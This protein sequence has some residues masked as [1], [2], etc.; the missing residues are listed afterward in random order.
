[1]VA[2]GGAVELSVHFNV[3]GQA[4]GLVAGRVEVELKAAPLLAVG[5]F[6][7]KALVVHLADG[8]K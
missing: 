8:G 5:A 2:H 7:V 6:P 4:E 1:M 3:L